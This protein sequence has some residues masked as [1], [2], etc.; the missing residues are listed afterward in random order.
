MAKIAL[1]QINPTVGALASNSELIIKYCKAAHEKGAEL[2]IFGEMALTGYPIE[3]LALR[4]SFQQASKKALIDIAKKLSEMHLGHLQVIVG[5]L[6]SSPTPESLGKPFG[7][8]QNAAA[9]IQ[10][11]QILKTYAK[12]HLPNYGVFDEFRYFLKGDSG[13]S[14]EFAGLKYSLAICE[15]IWQDGDLKV[16]KDSDLLIVINGSPYEEN[17]DDVRLALVQK[18]AREFGCAVI[19]VNLVGAQDELVFD[20]DSMAVNSAGDLI[21]RAPQFEEALLIIDSELTASTIEPP[22]AKHEEI[23]EA[24]VLGLKDYVEKNQMPSV[25]LGLSGGIDSALTAAI[26]FD[27]LGS[28]RVY[29]VALPSEFS[30]SHS[31]EDAK[32]LAENLK[33]NFRTIPIEPMVESFRKSLKV[34]G[35]ADENLQA[36]ARGVT[37]MAISNQEGHLV[38]A[39]GNKSEIASG[40]STLYGDAV[41]GFAPIKDVPKTLVWEL[42]R[43][44]NEKAG[45]ELIPVSSIEKPPSAE[46]RPGQLDSDS[47]PDYEVLDQI[48]DA[49]V[50]RDQSALALAQVKDPALVSEVIKM[51]DRAEYKRRQYPPGTKISARAFGRDRRLPITS[52]WSEA[53]AG[54]S[55]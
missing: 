23:Y 48:I 42:S 34:S 24:L 54:L 29:G 33:I 22:L 3:D 21:A 52:R 41:G 13:C 46:L 47:L 50:R 39:T 1:A 19:Y 45:K 55:E 11:G 25:V 30:S 4:P 8:P 9:I 5:F 31:L 37:L 14:H 36:R 10:N 35:L 27:A 51:I 43:W 28:N 44:R 16:D 18:R 40:Y 32:A 6:D 49:Y 20:G 2:V 38:L 53:P 17:K 12:H 26:A 7:N 15:D